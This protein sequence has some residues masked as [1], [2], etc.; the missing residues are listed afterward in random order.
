MPAIEIIA[1]P[2]GFAPE[3]IR[4]KWIGVHIPL[5]EQVVVEVACRIGRAN[6]GGYEVTARQAIAALRA[7]GREEAANYWE[8]YAAGNLVFK[9]EACR[10]VE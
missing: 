9:K 1:I 8:T 3:H 4:Q 7:A 6:E 10:I 2:P 5:A